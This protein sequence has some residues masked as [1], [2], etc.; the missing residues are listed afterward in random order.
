VAWRAV[1]RRR[2]F[3]CPSWLGPLLENPYT[4]AVAGSSV[5]IERAG[6]RPGMRVLDAGSGPGRVS[7]PAA[8]TVWPGGEV[9]ALDVQPAM[10]SMLER[11][12][13]SQ[14]VPNVRPLLGAIGDGLVAPLNFDRAL[15]VTVLGEV[16]DPKRALLEIYGALKPGG[17][18]SVTEVLPDPHYVGKASLRRLAEEAGFRVGEEFGNLVAYTLNLVKPAP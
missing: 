6:L 15:L 11:N 14:G 3:P 17:I 7:I 16:P 8:G 5:L 4:N 13:R 2:F 1:S 9:V 18:L 12:A 10:L